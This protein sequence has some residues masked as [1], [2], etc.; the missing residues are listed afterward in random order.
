[1]AFYSVVATLFPVLALAGIV[2]V[3]A[4]ARQMDADE[5]ASPAMMWLFLISVLSFLAASVLGEVIALHALLYGP[6]GQE[7]REWVQ[8]ALVVAASQVFN[9]AL[10]LPIY[11]IYRRLGRW[12]LW[13]WGVLWSIAMALST[14]AALGWF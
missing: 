11:A 10:V 7:G 3:Q 6:P 13:S 2:E 4:W 12:V 14:W 5:Y 8:V 1:M 9:G